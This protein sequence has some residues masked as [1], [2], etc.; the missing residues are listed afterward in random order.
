[1]GMGIDAPLSSQPLFSQQL[2]WRASQKRH[3]ALIRVPIKLSERQREK[4]ERMDRSREGSG[5]LLFELRLLTEVVSEKK[6]NTSLPV[7]VFFS[8]CKDPPQSN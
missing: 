3:S 7:R 1:M 4:V 5:Q 8:L 6:I 2:T